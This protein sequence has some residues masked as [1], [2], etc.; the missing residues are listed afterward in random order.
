MLSEVKV[1]LCLIKHEKKDKVRLGN[2]AKE[3]NVALKG[4]WV[5]SVS[6]A[7]LLGLLKVSSCSAT[8]LWSEEVFKQMLYL[9]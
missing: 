2:K 4:I 5:S 9:P 7:Y 8:L 6:H 1:F 3:K